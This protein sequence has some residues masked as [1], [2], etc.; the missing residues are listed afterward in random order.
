MVRKILPVLSSV[1]LVPVAFVTLLL[2]GIKISLLSP[3][4]YKASLEE[5]KIYNR[6]F[7]DLVPSLSSEEKSFAMVTTDDLVGVVQDSASPQWLEAQADEFIDGVFSYLFG[8]TSSLD[9]TIS[10]ISLKNSVAEGLAEIANERFAAIPECTPAQLE[11]LSQ[12]GEDSPPAECFPPGAITPEVSADL[13][14][15]EYDFMSAI[16]D[17]IDVGE[18][19]LGDASEASVLNDLPRYYRYFQSGL[20]AVLG[21]FLLLAVLAV[22]PDRNQ[23]LKMFRRLAVLLLVIA[24]PV[25]IAAAAGNLYGFHFLEPKIVS[26]VGELGSAADNLA[27]VFVSNFF[28]RMMIPAG[29]VSVV[30]L[31]GLV[32]A[33]ILERRS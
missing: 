20:L 17:R 33:N 9:M 31:G 21:V 18:T 7:E 3:G 13:F 12:A 16:P 26:L 23:P 14:I 2:F 11:Q 8:E 15:K 28:L 4:F 5:T 25:L 19:I 29:I 1:I 27:K 30:V 24:I 22:S 32:G 6:S 10:L